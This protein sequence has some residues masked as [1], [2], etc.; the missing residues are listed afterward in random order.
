MVRRIAVAAL[1]IAGL[2]LVARG[3]QW[4]LDVRAV[5]VVVGEYLDAL[6]AGDRARALGC[7]AP[8]RRAEIEA[9]EKSGTDV[10]DRSLPDP[11]WTWRVHHVDLAGNAA[12][13]ELWI[14]KDGFKIQPRLHLSRAPGLRWKI[15]GIEPVEIDPRWE[16]LRRAQARAAD[17][18]TALELEHALADRPNVRVKRLA[19]GARDW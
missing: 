7:L 12:V 15:A 19:A 13:A 8:E 10:A 18:R 5:R 2:F 6:R 16:D 3:T 17:E 14:E 1:T 9:R 4:W 11:G